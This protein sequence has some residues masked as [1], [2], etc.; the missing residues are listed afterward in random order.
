[1]NLSQ[2]ARFVLVGASGYVVNLAAF[3]LLY[4]AGVRMVS[5]RTP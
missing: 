1:M 3:S 5:L 2:P 4:A